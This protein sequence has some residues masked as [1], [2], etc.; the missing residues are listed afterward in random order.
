MKMKFATELLL[1]LAL[2]LMSMGCDSTGSTGGGGPASASARPGVSETAN[3]EAV[4]Q[5]ID[6]CRVVL[7]QPKTRAS[8]ILVNRAHS[9]RAT[10]KGRLDLAL[11]RKSGGYNV[12]SDRQIDELLEAMKVRNA[13]VL[14]EPFSREDERYLNAGPN[15]ISG[16][17]GIIV[18][19]NGGQRTKYV[20]LKPGNDPVLA[21]KYRVF[22][23]LKL[24]IAAIYR[25]T[26]PIEMPEAG[27]TG[28]GSSGQFTVPERVDRVGGGR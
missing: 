1:V 9:K 6:D 7:Y 27:G 21:A 11:G 15:D 20:G 19:E 10:A 14:E 12:L 22:V 25:S 26:G 23:D 2:A 8:M 28:A 18:V 24:L 16:Y 4:Y 17:K 5:S 13:N 3:P